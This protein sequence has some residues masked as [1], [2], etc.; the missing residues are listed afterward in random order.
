MSEFAVGLRTTCPACG[1]PLTVSWQNSRTLDSEEPKQVQP[2]PQPTEPVVSAARMFE[3]EE[4]PAPKAGK[5]HCDRCGRPFR[6]DWDRHTTAEGMLCHICSNLV[7]PADPTNPSSGYVPPI[8]S[9]R[10]DR[11]L[12][13]AAPETV[14]EEEPEPQSWWEKNM[15]SDETM[16]KVALYSGIA[17]IVLALLVFLF[18]TSEPPSPHT[19]TGE[20]EVTEAITPVAGAAYWIILGITRYFGSFLGLYLF[21]SWGNRLPNE[22]FVLNLIALAPIVLGVMLLSLIPFTGWI[23]AA[24]LIFGMYGF[25][26]GDLLRFPVS[27]FVARIFEFF[28]W[29]TLMGILGNIAT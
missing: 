25:E 3:A 22:R 20:E 5:H 2:A 19:A 18:D 24:L 7:R 21:L 1:S 23:F 11:D 26:W 8:D 14:V 13:P 28:L 9:I 15:P 12:T 29:V 16:Q 4:R 27:G 17:V 6:G 10:L